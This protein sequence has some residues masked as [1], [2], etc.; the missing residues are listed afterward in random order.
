MLYTHCNKK[1][2]SYQQSSSNDNS[3]GILDFRAKTSFTEN[4]P[5]NTTQ[6]L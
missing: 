2:L 5:N 3:E 1:L 6:T 4:A